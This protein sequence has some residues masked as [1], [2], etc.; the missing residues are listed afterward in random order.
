M[1]NKEEFRKY[2]VK[3]KN[4]SGTS[5]DGY[6]QSIEHNCYSWNPWILKKT[7]CSM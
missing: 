2:A 3:D 7:Y 6:V 4:I 1:I 5:F